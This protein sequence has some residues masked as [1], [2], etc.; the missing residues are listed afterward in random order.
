M[1]SLLLAVCV[2]LALHCGE[3]ALSCDTVV[4]EINPC[5]PYLTQGG[6]VV[7]DTC[8]DATRTLNSQVHSNVDI[9][10]FCC[11]IQSAMGP[12]NENNAWLMSVNCN[13]RFPYVLCSC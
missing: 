13:E 7:P 1:R 3:A 6:D 9:H 4:A 10:R 2:V 12:I 8:C 11:C 5:V